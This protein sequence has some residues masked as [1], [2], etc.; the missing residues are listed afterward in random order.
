MR[1]V[2][3]ILGYGELENDSAISLQNRMLIGV[4]IFYLLVLSACASA[5]TGSSLRP[6]HAFARG[7]SLAQ[8]DRPEQWIKM[9]KHFPVLSAEIYPLGAMEEKELIDSVTP[10]CDKMPFLYQTR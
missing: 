10:G 8:M 7:R 5:A 1:R 4:I 3:Y 2:K 9:V 6:P